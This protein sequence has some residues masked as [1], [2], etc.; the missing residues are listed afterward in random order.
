M[1]EPLSNLTPDPDLLAAALEGNETAFT[2]LY[3]RR[4]GEIYRF[5]LQM[6]G[7]RGAAEDMVQEAFLTLLRVGERYEEAR[8]PVRAFLFGIAR[9]LVLRHLE[10]G[11][12]SW[13]ETAEGSAELGGDEDLLADL[14]R[15][16]T[17]E[18]IRQAVLSLPPVYREAVVLCDLNEASY[19]EAAAA[20][21]CPVGTVRSRL[22]RGRA[23]L[24][25]KLASTFNQESRNGVRQ[26]RFGEQDSAKNNLTVT[27]E[28]APRSI[29]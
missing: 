3:R 9:K 24:A 28:P 25:K 21:D 18:T 19:E 5:G 27:L 23:L 6:T 10:R 8:G 2:M 4:Q 1:A 13:T 11:F 14:T 29:K 15:Q 12:S 26:I 22:N 20:L 7:D 17:I 16:E